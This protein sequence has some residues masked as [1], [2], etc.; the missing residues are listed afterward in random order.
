V[1]QKDLLGR[2]RSS[3]DQEAK[4]IDL[5]QLRY[6]KGCEQIAVS[7]TNGELRSFEQCP[8]CY[9]GLMNL[10]Q[11]VSAGLAVPDDRGFWTVRHPP[12]PDWLA[13]A[14]LRSRG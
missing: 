9:G 13:Q 7:S 10:G 3:K 8:F 2:L 5:E 14:G 12:M 6:C 4:A 1:A 11:A